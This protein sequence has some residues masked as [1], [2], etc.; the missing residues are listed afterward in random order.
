MPGLEPDYLEIL[1]KAKGT[2]F[3]DSTLGLQATETHSNATFLSPTALVQSVGRPQ[4]HLA[5]QA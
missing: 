1:V 2:S 3:E 4:G 5:G